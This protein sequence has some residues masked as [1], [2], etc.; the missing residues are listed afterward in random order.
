MFAS[1]EKINY[2]SGPTTGC[3]F[4]LG[5]LYLGKS[6]ALFKLDIVQFKSCL[7]KSQMQRVANFLRE[8]DVCVFQRIASNMRG[9]ASKLVVIVTA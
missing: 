8:L 7:A 5:E 2:I 6:L 3:K 9:Q 4:L 1:I